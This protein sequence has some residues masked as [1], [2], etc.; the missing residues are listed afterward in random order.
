MQEN[1]KGRV[2]AFRDVPETNALRDSLKILGPKAEGLACEGNYYYDVTK[3]GI[4]FHGDGKCPMPR[5]S[6]CS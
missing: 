5:R 6:G 3:C 1:K 4:G 2:V